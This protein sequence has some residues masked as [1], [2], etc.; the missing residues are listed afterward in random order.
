MVQLTSY[1]PQSAK[2]RFSLRFKKL[3]QIELEQF[4]VDLTAAPVEKVL[5]WYSLLS[6]RVEAIDLA[7]IFVEACSLQRLEFSAKEGWYFWRW[8]VSFRFYRCHAW[9]D[10]VTS[11]PYNPHGRR[12]MSDVNDEIAN[13]MQELLIFPLTRSSFFLLNGP[14]NWRRWRAY[15]IHFSRL[16]IQSRRSDRCNELGFAQSLINSAG[17]PR[18]TESDWWPNL[19]SQ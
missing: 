16:C 9:F 19:R 5:R 12:Y 11:S 1:F 8:F 10:A 7:S 3:R 15:W 13:L 17:L 2:R 14:N 6:A 18:S 4:C